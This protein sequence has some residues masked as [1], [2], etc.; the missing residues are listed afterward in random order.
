MACICCVEGTLG[1]FS[2]RPLLLLSPLSPMASF[3]LRLLER[4]LGRFSALSLIAGE[5]SLVGASDGAVMVL[6]SFF[7]GF[8]VFEDECLR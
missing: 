3:D 2:A 7:E 5:A 4:L 1:K 6:E 8:G